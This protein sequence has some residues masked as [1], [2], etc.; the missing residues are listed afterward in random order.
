MLDMPDLGIPAEQDMSEKDSP[1]LELVRHLVEH[2]LR[3]LLT[4]A[5]ISYGKKR[6]A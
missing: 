5:T 6:R 4:D 1:D 2:K 3:L